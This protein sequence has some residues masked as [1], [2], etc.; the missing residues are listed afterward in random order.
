MPAKKTPKTEYS[1]PL[2]RAGIPAPVVAARDDIDSL[3]N[4]YEVG[5]VDDDHVAAN[6]GQCPPVGW[7]YVANDDGVVAYFADESDAFRHRLSE[8]NRKLNP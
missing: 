5:E 1:G 8:I 6:K 2:N 4:V 3:L 7:Y